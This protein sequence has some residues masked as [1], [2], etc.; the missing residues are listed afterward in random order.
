L[1]KASGRYFGFGALYPVFLRTEAFLVGAEAQ[2][3]NNGSVR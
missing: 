2:R 3:Q 1:G